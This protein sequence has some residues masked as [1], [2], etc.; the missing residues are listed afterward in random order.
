MST[1]SNYLSVS[2]FCFSFA[3]LATPALAQKVPGKG[4]SAFTVRLMNIEATAKETFRYNASLYNG[5]GHTQLYELRASAPEGWSTVF[6]TEGSQIAGLRMDSGRTQDISVE[7]TAAPSVKPGKYTV[8][9]VAITA[10]DTLRTDLEAVVK[11]NY[12][13]ELTTPSGR[14]SDEITEGRSKQIQLTV[15]NTGTLPLE[16]LELS[17]QAPMGWNATFEPA[18]IDRLDPDKEQ[19]IT[20][21][22][23]VPDKTIAGDYV[24][25]FTVRNNNANSNA[26]FRMTVKTSLLAGWIGMLVILLSLGIVYYLIR[27]YGRR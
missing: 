15:K 7:V 18:K 20:A 26:A 2:L 21:T 22:L 4:R 19:N 8:P 9:V 23:H 5:S 11:G 24:T 27:K 14:L 3:A 16:G 17:A 6:R 25:S 10:T 12:G 13:L 1:L